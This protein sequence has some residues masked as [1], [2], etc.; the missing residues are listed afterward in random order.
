[1]FEGGERSL[2]LEALCKEKNAPEERLKVVSV[3]VLCTDVDLMDRIDFTS[4]CVC[5]FFL[6]FQG[7]SR[8]LLIDNVQ[9]LH[10]KGGI[11]GSNCMTCVY[12]L[13]MQFGCMGGQQNRARAATVLLTS[14]SHRD[15][16]KQRETI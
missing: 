8:L 12:L 13:S 16:N 3:Y 9:T 14:V 11:V 10:F 6:Y 7:P 15:M 5:I 4:K 2:L 1:M